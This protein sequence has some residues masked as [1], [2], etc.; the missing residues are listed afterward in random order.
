MTCAS[1]HRQTL[2][3]FRTRHLHVIL[4]ASDMQGPS[5]ILALAPLGAKVGLN[6]KF[7]FLL[8]CSA[9]LRLGVGFSSSGQKAPG[10]AFG[11]MYHCSFEPRS[12]LTTAKWPLCEAKCSGVAPFFMGFSC[13]TLRTL[14]TLTLLS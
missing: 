14:A 2:E 9:V 11:Y 12:S 10:T 3:R 4:L 6:W 5:P 1:G 7:L 13:C 8:S